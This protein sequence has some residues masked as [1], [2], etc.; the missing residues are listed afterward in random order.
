M[1]VKIHKK[2]NL[3]VIS[4]KNVSKSYALRHIKPTLTDRFFTSFKKPVTFKALDNVSL[5]VMKG[6]RVG[7]MG[8]NGSGKTTLLKL[9]AGIA[10]PT[11]GEVVVRGKVVSLIDLTAGF[12]VDLTGEENIYLNGILL[13]MSRKEIQKKYNAIVAFADIGDFIHQPFYMYSS[14]MALR[15]G[16]AV[17]VHAEPDIF[18]MD[19]G[20]MVGD[21]DFR[22]KCEKKIA[23]MKKEG[24][25]II[26]VTHWIDFL[27]RNVDHIIQMDSLK[28]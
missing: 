6:S 11:S 12:H 4:L 20:F 13:G 28:S 2:N 23:S 14:G 8:P 26:I 10:T 19:E 5:E 15:L 16:F 24:I 27:K 17:A 7:I 9:I 1:P 3:P 22:K 25:T 21:Q 18:L